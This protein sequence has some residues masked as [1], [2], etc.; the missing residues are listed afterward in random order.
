MVIVNNFRQRYFPLGA[1]PPHQVFAECAAGNH[2]LRRVLAAIKTIGRN[3][4]LC[5]NDL[6]EQ[7][8][9]LLS[10]LPHRP[11][12]NGA[13]EQLEPS[14]DEDAAS[15]FF[16][17]LL[18]VSEDGFGTKSSGGSDQRTQTIQNVIRVISGANASRSSSFLPG[19]FNSPTSASLP[20]LPGSRT[21]GKE[22]RIEFSKI[23]ITEGPLVLLIHANDAEEEAR[24][25]KKTFQSYSIAVL[26]ISEHE[27]LLVQAMDVCCELW[28]GEV[29]FVIPLIS[30]EYL[31][32]VAVPASHDSVADRS[33]QM[34]RYLHMLM[35]NELITQGINRR[36]R[37]LVSASLRDVSRIK[38]LQRPVYSAWKSTEKMKDMA[39]LIIRSVAR[40]RIARDTPR[41]M[42]NDTQIPLVGVK[43][44]GDHRYPG[45]RDQNIRPRFH[46]LIALIF[47]GIRYVLWWLYN[48]FITRRLPYIDNFNPVQAKPIYGVPLGGLG[49]GSIGRTIYGA[50][51]RFQMV[52]GI[53]DYETPRGDNFLISVKRPGRTGD[54]ATI[55]KSRLVPYECESS[56]ERLSAWDL[57]FPAS[58]I[59]FTGLYPRAW[60][61][62]DLREEAGLRVICRQVKMADDTAGLYKAYYYWLL[63]EGRRHTVSDPSKKDPDRPP[64]GPLALP[65]V[66]PVLPNDYK[67]SSLPVAVFVWTVQNLDAE[68]KEVSL[69]FTFESGTTGKPEKGEIK[70]FKLETSA[71]TAGVALEG[72]LDNAQL[73]YSY[74]LVAPSDHPVTSA[75][76]NPD[77]S[78]EDLWEM[79]EGHSLQPQMDPEQRRGSLGV[80]LCVSFKV[81]AK[82]S[83]T[84]PFALAW[85]TPKL[86]FPLDRKASF[87]RRYTRWFGRDLKAG[88]KMAVHALNRFREWE[89]M[90]GDWQNPILSDT[91]LPAWYKSALFN[92]LYY[93]SDGGTLWL[94]ETGATAPADNLSDTRK[95]MGVFGYLEA[96]EYL[97]YNTVDVHF[98][99]SA[100]LIR[101]WP[102][103]QKTMQLQVAENIPEEDGQK[104]WFL[105]T[106]KRGLRKTA[107]C[108]PHDLGNPAEMPFIKVNAYISDDTSEWKDLNLKFV[109]MVYRDFYV[110]RDKIYLR[111]MWPSV[112]TIM[113]RSLRWDKDGDGLIENQGYPPDQ[114]YDSWTMTG[115][116]A[117]AGG[118]WLAALQVTIKM[119][120]LMGEEAGK[121]QEKLEQGR[122]SYEVRRWREAF[123]TPCPVTEI[124][125]RLVRVTSNGWFPVVQ[126]KLWMGEWFAFDVI[127]RETIMADQLCGYW[128][129]LSSGEARSGVFD[130]RKVRLALNSIFKNNVEGFLDGKSGAV[131]GYIPGVGVDPRAMQSEEVWTGVSYT[132]AATMVYEGLVREGFKTAEGIY[133]Q[134]W[135]ESG[136]G[137]QTPEALFEGP[138][139]R[140]IGYMR[141]LSVWAIQAALETGPPVPMESISMEAKIDTSAQRLTPELRPPPPDLPVD[142]EAVEEYYAKKAT[143]PSPMTP[144]KDQ[145]DEEEVVAVKEAVSMAQAVPQLAAARENEDDEEAFSDVKEQ[146][147]PDFRGPEQFD[148]EETKEDEFLKPEEI[149][150]IDASGVHLGAVGGGEVRTT[151]NEFLESDNQLRDEARM[152]SDTYDEVVA[153]RLQEEEIQGAN[154]EE[155]VGSKPDTLGAPE[156]KKADREISMF[157]TGFVSKDEFLQCQE[158][159]DEVTRGMM[160][161]LEGQTASVKH[162]EEF[163]Q[164]E[165]TPEEMPS[166]D[167]PEEGGYEFRMP[168][169]EVEEPAAVSSAAPLTQSAPP[170][171]AMM[172]SAKEAL[173]DGWQA[174]QGMMAEA[175]RTLVEG[176]LEFSRQ[177]VDTIPDSAKQVVEVVSDRPKQIVPVVSEKVGDLSGKASDTTKDFLGEIATGDLLGV[178]ADAT[179]DSMGEGTEVLKSAPKTAEDLLKD[180]T[181]TAEHVG[182]KTAETL[183]DAP[184]TA[185]DLLKDATETAEHVV[186]ETAETLKDAPKTVELLGETPKESPDLLQEVSEAAKDEL[187]ESSEVIREVPK[188]AE[189]LLQEVSEASKDVRNVCAE[190]TPGVLSESPG[191]TGELLDF[192]GSGKET[193]VPRP[194]EE[195]AEASDLLGDLSGLGPTPV[196]EVESHILPSR[197]EEVTREFLSTTDEDERDS[198]SPGVDTRDDD[199]DLGELLSGANVGGGIRED[200]MSAKDRLDSTNASNVSIASGYVGGGEDFRKPFTGFDASTSDA[201]LDKEFRAGIRED[202][203]VG[204]EML[205]NSK[206]S[207][208]SIASGFVGG[209]ESRQNEDVTRTYSTGSSDGGIEMVAPHMDSASHILSMRDNEIEEELQRYPR[210]DASVASIAGGFVGGLTTGEGDRLSTYVPEISLSPSV[211]EEDRKAG[212]LVASSVTPVPA[213]ESG[214]TSGGMK[215]ATKTDSDATLMGAEGVSGAP[216]DETSDGILRSANQSVVRSASDAPGIGDA[217]Q[218]TEST[219]GKQ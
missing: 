61:D 83:Q 128:A 143:P 101:L 47:V 40:K 199:D 34:V 24:L 160:E 19:P 173:D 96:H 203:M 36:V 25:V 130:P 57:K 9:E 51:T 151:I 179:K 197:V 205:D 202:L 72:T 6:K 152:V 104:M 5:R 10:E 148:D 136:L 105:A 146:A 114:T 74:T 37:T 145:G 28:F 168:E 164:Q 159:R 190:K 121:W 48:R 95:E 52:P 29:D 58:K 85:D 66:S 126:G 8:Q 115:P 206:A 133:R 82:G 60:Y 177:L 129:L 170:R 59:N 171:E 122:S 155:T 156:R 23:K 217:T 120:Q 187:K 166:F 167:P 68:A 123:G 18:G 71:S 135:E 54:A 94:E 218:P 185:E 107:N 55:F 102:E 174:G 1:L 214:E 45:P 49:A 2:G 100:A 46:Q 200:L 212:E 169:S 64:C 44:K 99:S 109:L 213:T 165:R 176:S 27:D 91:S 98:Y 178:V 3:D 142:H 147:E 14:W 12:D 35:Q 216:G 118:L 215:P 7:L 103:I 150:D 65:K 198:V 93:L 20:N 38:E 132:L 161:Q 175:G 43:V 42:E 80:A 195:A 73:P 78:G 131:N 191:V 79:F 90:I 22:E 67:D 189:N 127:H 26:N 144:S 172:D 204:S 17:L 181:E 56:S 124:E 125:N 69:V 183:K 184:E 211:D 77:G 50:F 87:L 11:A 76:F 196:V 33:L 140:A 192:S 41:L 137:Y 163:L 182:K 112:E 117:Y 16:N 116:S 186:K 194:H 106:G 208:V 53:Y 219:Q 92:E 4:I 30:R 62:I 13:L 111:E 138:T 81:E 88:P 15:Y 108:V 86:T 188:T 162:A 75:C 39:N 210:D 32:A 139:Y 207:T 84:V 154:L 209:I 157:D 153:Q 113:E 134:V 149:L 110:T 180:A 158:A 141:P 63:G 201:D 119:A 193:A 70:G 31:K 97:M 89:E 21:D